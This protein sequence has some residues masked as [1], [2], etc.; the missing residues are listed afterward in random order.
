MTSSDPKNS[1][2]ETEDQ[3]PVSSKNKVSHVT[4]RSQR[5]RR[6]IVAALSDPGNDGLNQ[7]QLAR[8]VGVSSRTLRA[9][10]KADPSILIEARQLYHKRYVPSEMLDVDR[11]MLKK[12]GKGADVPAAKLC[13]QRFDGLGTHEGHQETPLV[14]NIIP[15]ADA[16]TAAAG[17]RIRA[18]RGKQI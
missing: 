4:L 9:H 6:K 2:P 16:G 5:T 8:K 3:A 12:A 10:L 7:E 13:Y 14:I 15:R 17:V 1:S 11:S 18:R